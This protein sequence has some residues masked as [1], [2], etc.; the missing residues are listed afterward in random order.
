MSVAIGVFVAIPH[1]LD[2]APVIREHEIKRPLGAID[3]PLIERVDE[4]LVSDARGPT[5]AVSWLHAK[6][7]RERI[8]YAGQQSTTE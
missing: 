8:R 4:L 6:L 3:P 2:L 7:F 1:A 5:C